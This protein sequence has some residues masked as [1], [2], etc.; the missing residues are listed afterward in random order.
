MRGGLLAINIVSKP[1]SGETRCGSLRYDRMAE[2]MAMLPTPPE[3]S[4]AM[5]LKWS[6]IADRVRPFLEQGA[7]A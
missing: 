3:E 5:T 7:G 4:R 2:A 6:K 1:Q